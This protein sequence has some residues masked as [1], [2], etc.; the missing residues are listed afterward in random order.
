M[1]NRILR[2]LAGPDHEVKDL[3]RAVKKLSDAQRDHSASVLARLGQLDDLIAQR[4]TGKDANEILHALRATTAL[5]GK[6][7]PAGDGAARSEARL[8]K[9]LDAVA[10]GN[11]PIIVGPW[12][13]E[14]GFEL[15][16]W[17]PFVEWFRTRW[18]VAPERLVIVSRGGT[19]PW[20]GVAGARYADMF[21]LMTPA[22]FRARTDQH[23]HKQRGV[24]PFD[25][26]IARDAQVRLGIAD[27]A[28]LHP[29]LMY[30]L[31]A[32]YWKDEAG[33]GLIDR[34]TIHRRI[35]AFDDP[36]LAGLPTNYVAVRF[37]FSDCFPDTAGNRAYATRAVEAI[38]RHT[39]V[40]LLNPNL[41]LDDHADAVTATSSRI[42]SI[43]AALSPER[44]LAAQ[45][46]VI[47]RAKAFVGTYGGYSY[48]APLCG[49]PAIGLYSEL[50]FKLH[51]LAAAQRICEKLGC[52]TVLA[53]DA[54]QAEAVHLATEM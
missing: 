54:A 41:Q 3:A 12:S 52:A 11:R 32:P 9:S 51:H 5:V 29:R 2:R 27:A 37:Y 34:F 47:A 31:F 17:I 4:S 45:T 20:Y 40:V 43:A 36:A 16:Y 1:L 49:V 18:R 28:T 19:E 13:G 30:R 48:L 8:H 42:T 14:V 21:S 38:A 33:F 24:S 15:L 7:L 50:T 25:E 46:A 44:N 26:T 6:G 10:K 39:P 22:E 53:V 35:A 23:E